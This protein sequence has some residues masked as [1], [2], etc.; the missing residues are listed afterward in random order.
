MRLRFG[1]LHDPEPERGRDGFGT[2]TYFE[3]LQDGGDVMID[4]LRR[5]VQAVSELSIRVPMHQ[6]CQHLD[7]ARSE[8]AGFSRVE[9]RGPRGIPRTPSSRRR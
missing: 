4:R 3:L 5:N 9:V 7:F 1:C 6:Q 8:P 2:R